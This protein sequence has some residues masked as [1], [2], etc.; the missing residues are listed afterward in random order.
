MLKT[1]PIGVVLHPADQ[2]AGGSFLWQQACSKTRTYVVMLVERKQTMAGYL[3]PDV[4]VTV[5]RNI[6]L[7]SIWNISWEITAFSFHG[8]PILIKGFKSTVSHGTV[9]QRLASFPQLTTETPTTHEIQCR[10][11][12][13]RCG[14]CDH[15]FLN[16]VFLRARAYDRVNSLGHSGRVKHQKA[17]WAMGLR[18]FLLTILPRLSAT[19]GMPTQDG[20][21]STFHPMFL[22]S[23]GAIIL[24]I[25]IAGRRV[26]LAL[27]LVDF[28]AQFGLL[29]KQSIFV[30]LSS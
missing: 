25:C 1:I 9:S 16:R 27:F 18:F 3:L 11:S 5:A 12:C 22:F 26:R 4:D 21:Y 23:C 6:L 17:Y 30:F 20:I 14:C 8:Q 7:P 29:A 13:V 24:V 15:G 2:L 19:G 28:L 10:K